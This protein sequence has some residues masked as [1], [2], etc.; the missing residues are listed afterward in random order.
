MPIFALIDCNNFYASCERVFNPRLDNKAVVVLSNND[1][2]IIARSNEAKK[3]GIPMGAPY[4]IWK[5]FCKKHNVFVFSSNY[6]LYGDMSHRVMKLIESYCPSI[7]VYSIDEAFITLDS[8]QNFNINQY[9][10]QLKNIIKKFTGIP[11]SIGI[12]PTKTLA[13][14]A[15]NYAKKQTKVGVFSL[16]DEHI[17][18]KVLAQFPVENIWGVGSQITKRLIPHKIFNAKDLHNADLKT[19]RK[20]FSVVIEQTIKELR[21]TAC[22]GLEE[23]TPR[24]QIVSSRS[25]GKSVKTLQELEEALSH[26]AS[27]ACSKL[28]KQGSLARGVSVFIQTNF[29]QQN[30]PQYGN[31]AYYEFPTPTSDTSYVIY[32]AKLCLRKIF[33]NGYEYHKTGIMLMDLLPNSVY[34][35][36]LFN[37]DDIEPKRDKLIKTVDKINLNLGKNSLFFAAEGVERSWRLRA[38]MRSSRYTT[39]WKELPLVYCNRN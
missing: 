24:K 20:C 30:R 18:E 7:E 9:I 4:H 25:F 37:Q 10:I 32:I 8:F 2:C 31:S 5:S 17:R 1:G 21:G 35:Y 3:L 36:N 29:F 23:A 16:L 12:G 28:R 15:N 11:V 27:I 19:L 33:K 13:K 38:Q 14:I 22:Y 26:Y 39:Q 6:P 34:Q